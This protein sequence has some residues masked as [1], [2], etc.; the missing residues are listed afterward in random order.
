MRKEPFKDARDLAFMSAVV[1]FDFKGEWMMD[2]RE[3]RIRQRAHQIWEREGRPGGREDAHW[4]QAAREVAAEETIATSEAPGPA[5]SEGLGPE[6]IGADA[7]SGGI[8]EM[9]AAAVKPPSSGS[10]SDDRSTRGEG[11]QSGSNPEIEGRRATEPPSATGASGLSS[12][13]QSG[14]SAPSSSPAVGVGSLGTGGGST[15]GKPTGTAK[16]TG[17]PKR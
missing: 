4:E 5:E 1:E 14:G 6:E 11:K 7:Q 15:G 12:G 3:E 2:E 17:S 9:G 16:R 8:G 13:L 10:D